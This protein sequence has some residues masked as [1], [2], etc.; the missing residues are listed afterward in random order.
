MK[1]RN[2]SKYSIGATVYYH[3]QEIQQALHL[4]YGTTRQL[5]RL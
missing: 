1:Q 4:I 3:D 5:F 2:Q